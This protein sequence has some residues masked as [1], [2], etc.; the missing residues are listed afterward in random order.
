MTIDTVCAVRPSARTAELRQWD[1]LVSVW[2][3]DLHRFH[4][5]ARELAH[6]RWAASAPW[7]CPTTRPGLS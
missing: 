3:H 4:R 7:R 2:Q 1:S 5:L 6:W